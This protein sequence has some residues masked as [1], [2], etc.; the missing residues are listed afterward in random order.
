MKTNN[1]NQR[2]LRLIIEVLRAIHQGT[3]EE[4]LKAWSEN[5]SELKD[6][7]GN[8]FCSNQQLSSLFDEILK[9]IREER[10]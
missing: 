5:Y 7:A 1:E 9:K 2:F 8:D 10:T 4:A 3:G 6:I